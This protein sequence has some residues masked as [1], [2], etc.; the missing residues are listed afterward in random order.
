MEHTPL[1]TRE[2]S[3]LDEALE[4]EFSGLQFVDNIRVARVGHQIDM[5]SYADK[6]KRGCCGSYDTV[7]FIKEETMLSEV[8]YSYYV[9]FL[10]GCNY[11]H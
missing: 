2:Y 8:W 9:P 4:K 6:I 1:R 3:S 11:G 7:V 10:I 5:V